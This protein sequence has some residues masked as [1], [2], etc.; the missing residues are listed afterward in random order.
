M[1]DRNL[2][3]HHVV[4]TSLWLAAVALVVA[5]EVVGMVG[6]GH[7]GLITA[8]LAMI[9]NIRGFFCNAIKRERA[10]FELGREYGHSVDAE[11]RSLH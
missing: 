9:A 5:G 8:G 4:A 3:V 2:S 6:L 11:V 7:L 10:V 1:N